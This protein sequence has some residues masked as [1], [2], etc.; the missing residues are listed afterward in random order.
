MSAPRS[1]PGSVPDDTTRAAARRGMPPKV[2]NSD[3]GVPAD[4]SA[5]TRDV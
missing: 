3:T 4:A 2:R 1:V 5:T